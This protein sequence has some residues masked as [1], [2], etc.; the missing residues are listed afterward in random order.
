MPI[1]FEP[2]RVNV[3]MACKEGRVLRRIFGRDDEHFGPG[4]GSFKEGA[5]HR[6]ISREGLREGRFPD[7][8]R[9]HMHPEHPVARD[10]VL[11][12]PC[13]PLFSDLY[14]FRDDTGR[15]FDALR[16]KGERGGGL[17]DRGGIDDRTFREQGQQLC[18]RATGSQK[19]KDVALGGESWQS[20]NRGTE[21]VLREVVDL[22]L[23]QGFAT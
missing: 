3:E 23:R 12:R 10:H 4:R 14:P 19:I 2:V 16:V 17:G 18:G 11:H 21:S 5:A 9:R 7:F 20:K 1:E 13:D 22:L 15:V 8:G 6:D